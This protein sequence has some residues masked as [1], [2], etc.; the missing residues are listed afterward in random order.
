VEALRMSPTTKKGSNTKQKKSG[1]DSTASESREKSS[2]S[3]KADDGR[4]TLPVGSAEHVASGN[5][6]DR[7][8]SNI[9]QGTEAIDPVDKFRLFQLFQ[10]FQNSMQ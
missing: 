9:Q 7:N 2:G 5:L 3:E 4:N 1:E 10:E 6:S 8:S